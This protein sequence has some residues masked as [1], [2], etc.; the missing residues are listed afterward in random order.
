[1]FKFLWFMLPNCFYNCFI[2]VRIQEFHPH[3][4]DW[5]ISSLT[6]KAP[7]LLFFVFA[8]YLLKTPGYLSCRVF[9]CLDFANFI[10]MLLY[11]TFLSLLVS[12]KLKVGS[13]GIIWLR[14]RFLVVN[15]LQTVLYIVFRRHI[16]MLSL[17]WC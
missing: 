3:A 14:F 13:R 9:H 6:V 17:L 12:C 11:K 5:H 15:P 8:I 7:S 4:F 2:E 16:I 1:M 10:S